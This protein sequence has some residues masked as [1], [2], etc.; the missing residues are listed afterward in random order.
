VFESEGKGIN[1]LDASVFLP[2]ATITTVILETTQT[3]KTTI[4]LITPPVQ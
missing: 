1:S 2:I 4:V 3:L